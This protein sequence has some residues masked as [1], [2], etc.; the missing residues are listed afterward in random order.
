MKNLALCP[1][2]K[3]EFIPGLNDTA[4]SL[5]TWMQVALN[6]MSQCALLTDEITWFWSAFIQLFVS[7]EF[8]V[9]RLCNQI[10]VFSYDF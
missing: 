8:S 4:H 7:Q 10:L 3:R 5:G 1:K 9:E 6:S 2:G